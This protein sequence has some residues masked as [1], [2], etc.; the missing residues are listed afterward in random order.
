MSEETFG[1]VLKKARLSCGLSQ[2]DLAR[3]LGVGTSHIGYLE[4]GRRRPSLM[5][6]SALA[7]EL[8]VDKE[9]LFLLSHH[10]AKDLIKCGTRKRTTSSKHSAWQ[11]LLADKATL[12]RNNI[13][14]EELEV[15][16][17]ISSLGVIKPRDYLFILTAIRKAIK[18]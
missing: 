15:L 9:R 14:A 1:K 17:H 12:V 5:L 11:E 4:Q 13:T 16:S 3:K 18:E 7:N 2:R 10:E 6:L 8:S